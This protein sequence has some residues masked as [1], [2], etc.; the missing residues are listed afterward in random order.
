MPR[1]EDDPSVVLSVNWMKYRIIISG[2]M[3]LYQRSM[4]AK[5]TEVTRH[6]LLTGQS[7]A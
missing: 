6:L 4:L 7:C 2:S 1:I 5:R 3:C